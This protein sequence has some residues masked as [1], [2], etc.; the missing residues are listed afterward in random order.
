[1]VSGKAIEGAPVPAMPTSGS[2]FDGA[3][4]LKELAK[5][6]LLTSIPPTHAFPLDLTASNVS[7]SSV[8]E[9]LPTI[10]FSFLHAKEATVRSKA[11]HNLA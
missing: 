2:G 4:G 11:I 5:F 8:E 3:K 7:S 10:D 6:G 1:M 9:Q